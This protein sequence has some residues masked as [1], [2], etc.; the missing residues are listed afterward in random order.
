MLLALA[1][2][3]WLI[4][5]M[6]K[7]TAAEKKKGDEAIEKGTK[8][9][10]GGLG[11]FLAGRPLS[12]KT[13]AAK[14][15]SGAGFWDNAP[16]P[17]APFA[18]PAAEMGSI[19]LPGPTPGATAFDWV[20]G[21]V[22]VWQDWLD[23]LYGQVPRRLLQLADWAGIA[24]VWA[25]TGARA[26]GRAVR[27]LL[28]VPVALWRALAS[29]GR[30][31]YVSVLALRVAVP[32]AAYAYVV[33]PGWTQAGLG[34]AG[35]VAAGAAATGPGGLKWWTGPQPTDDVLYGPALWVA[36]KSG[37]HLPEEA[38][39]ADWLT[40]PQHLDADGAQ[41]RLRLP[42]EFLGT[43]RDR[44]WLDEIV[45]MR[46]PGDWVS[47]WHLMGGAHSA[48]WT[49]KPVREIRE[50]LGDEATYGPSLWAALRITLR[51]PEE[52]LLW[53]WLTIPETLAEEDAAVLL[54]LP[55]S[56]VGSDS[57]KIA[58]D[59]MV[60]SRLPG[61]WVSAWQL[62]GAEH[63][64][65]WTHKPKPKPKPEPPADVDFLS[66]EVQQFLNTLKPG[67]LLVGVDAFG[68]FLVKKLSGETS[69]WALSIGS[70]GGK[71]AFLYMLIAQL[72]RQRATV[73]SP[74]VKVVSLDEYEG[75][76]GIHIY[77][78]PENVQDMRAAIDWVKEE[79]KA[80]TFIAKKNKARK[81][82]PLVLIIEEGNEFGDISREWWADNKPEKA[83]AGDPVWGDVASIMR[84]GRHVNVHVIAV[85]QDLDERVFGNKGL[86]GLFNLIMMGS[87]TVQ[88]WRKII[89]RNPV[90]ESPR[91]A[92]R[93]IAVEGG[94]E[95]SFQSPWT[96]EANFRAYV[97]AWRKHTGYREEDL[98]GLPPRRSVVDVPALLRGTVHEEEAGRHDVTS[99]TAETLETAP[100]APLADKIPG[101]R[102]TLTKGDAQPDSQDDA[103]RDALE[104][105]LEPYGTQAPA[106]AEEELLSLAAISRKFEEMGVKR[107]SNTMSAH[108]RR[109]PEFPEGI[110]P[111]G[112]QK[113]RFSEIQAFYEKR[114]DAEAV[115]QM[116]E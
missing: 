88:Q 8:A 87:Y 108:K 97:D 29:Y 92:G 5:Q 54:G 51:L 17:P 76:A 65:T 64:V 20:V 50:L 47:A 93:I 94:D 114:E 32:A 2:I 9:L 113:Y 3:G 39:Q 83:K 22:V 48:T 44:A 49:A 28:M 56:F 23:G 59:A 104:R 105:A 38:E 73:V 116:G 71:S 100:G 34:V 69:H 84:L 53:D 37:L 25:A 115:A 107:P 30:W 74:D 90:P 96:K 18:Q 111:K 101:Q 36:V 11:R 27:G 40:V 98:F 7:R 58:L 35:A 26:L 24:V 55:L 70:G 52:D 82:D 63:H 67:E 89:A 62:M 15:E 80:R 75:A 10:A 95:D 85:F 68:R 81:F 33:Q 43:D 61:E 14:K 4:S 79:T 31:A 99:R 72:V 66:E 77:N 91:K 106:E 13:A 19:A 12:A 110:G 41:V 42:V 45:N 1:A 109:Y 86:R 112:K 103:L 78:D 60:N 21:K 57:E 102:V 6:P 46:L 16:V